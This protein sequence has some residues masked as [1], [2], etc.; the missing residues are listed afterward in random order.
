[1]VMVNRRQFYEQ[2][3]L[4]RQHFTLGEYVNKQNCRIWGPENSQI[5]EERPLH[6]EK[7]NVWCTL[8]SVGVIGRDTAQYVS[9]SG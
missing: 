2:N 9:K 5:I 3:F 4:Q 7:V 6:P 8:W 1:M